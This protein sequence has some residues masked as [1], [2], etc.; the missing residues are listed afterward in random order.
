YDASLEK[1][2][3]EFKID[4]YRYM[5]AS[6]DDIG[7]FELKATEWYVKTNDGLAAFSQAYMTLS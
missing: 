1:T 6:E 7:V 5:G 2:I 3:N 4:W